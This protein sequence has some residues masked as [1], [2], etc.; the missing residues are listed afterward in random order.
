MSPESVIGIDVGGA[1]LK[2]V[3]GRDVVIHYCPMW[4]DS[5]LTELLSIYSDKTA[6]VVMSGELA[7]GFPDKNAGI[8]YIVKSVRDAVPDSYFYGMDGEFHT[9]PDRSLAAA[10]WLASADYLR[11]E[12]PS[13][14][15]VDMGSTTVD[16]IP[17]NSF[18]NLKGMTDL[19]RLRE[20]YL[21][22]SGTLRTT[23]PAVIRSASVNGICTPVSSEYFAQSA[24]VHLVLGN[25]SESDYTSPA[26][27]GAGTDC[28]SSLRR[29]A[30]VVC[31]DLCEIGEDGALDIA[32]DFYKKQ[33]EIIGVA[34]R[35][36]MDSTG[37]DSIISGGIGS[38]I[39]VNEFGGLDL[40]KESRKLSDALPAFAVREVA[41]RRGEF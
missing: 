4:Q 35:D 34:V 11:N 2:I 28:N 10:N 27:D 30:R 16:I 40:R 24:D 19:D 7:D 37:C 9:S 32:R 39:I 23:V 38:H 1:N 12:Y 22:Y 18:E 29:L 31:S 6:A 41:L 15:L 21:V 36:A 5:P 25:I 26:A 17:L 33:M 3:D 8:E 14:L 13:S 20:G